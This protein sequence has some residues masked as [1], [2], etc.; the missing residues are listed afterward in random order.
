MRLDAEALERVGK[1]LGILAHLGRGVHAALTARRQQGDRR[2]NILGLPG[3]LRLR[4]DKFLC[5]LLLCR[6]RTDR[7]LIVLRRGRFVPR[8]GRLLLRGGLRPV[9]RL[10]RKLLHRDRLK[11]R[12]RN[13]F[14]RERCL[15]HD[16]HGM[17]CR[18]KRLLRDIVTGHR[19]RSRSR[20]LLLLLFQIFIRRGNAGL[21]LPLFR[22]FQR[23]I[24]HG[25]VKFRRTALFH[26]GDMA[27]GH[28]VDDAF[29]RV[30]LGLRLLVGLLQARAVLD[31]RDDAVDRHIH[32]GDDLHEHHKDQDDI[33]ADDG[34]SRLQQHGQQTAQQA[35]RRSGNA[36]LEQCGHD[37][38]L[39]HKGLALNEMVYCRDGQNEREHADDAQAHRLAAARKQDD[40]RG[41]E[42]QRQYVASRLP[43]QA[44]DERRERPDQ[45][46]R[47]IE[48]AD[49]GEDRQ[50]N[51]DER[52]DLAAVLR[53]AL[54]RGGLLCSR[55]FNGL[56]FPCHDSPPF[57]H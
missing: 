44:R 38:P 8:R 28:M 20:A 42:G 53:L 26:A 41:D 22:L 21:F 34:D 18:V 2:E 27:V 23:G 4:D 3:L 25:Q 54:L 50:K 45:K 7:R 11:S 30:L 1:A 57:R 32:D 6:R 40:D 17:L 51:A 43:E 5:V 36:A 12:L 37:L 24:V 31:S 16:R 10:L 48:A 52:P 9:L 13:R 55:L 29:G 33:R 56:R 49:D 14:L 47:G 35:A 19:D 39:P 15:R 46:G